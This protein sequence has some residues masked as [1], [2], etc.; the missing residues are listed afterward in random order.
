MEAPDVNKYVNQSD[1]AVRAGFWYRIRLHKPA[2]TQTDSMTHV[3]ESG[4]EFMAPISGVEGKG[5]EGAICD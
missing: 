1:K 3:P 5:E 2:L 4:A